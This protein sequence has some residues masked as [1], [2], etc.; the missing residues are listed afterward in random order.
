M[1]TSDFV[2]HAYRIWRNYI[3]ILQKQTYARIQYSGFKRVVVYVWLP[4]VHD[5]VLVVA[6][7]QEHAI[8]E[9]Q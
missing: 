4:G 2:P 1:V 9:H 6:T 3:F 8:R 7:V 5:M